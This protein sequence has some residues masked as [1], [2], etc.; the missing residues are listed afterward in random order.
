MTRDQITTLVTQTVGQIDPT[1]IAICND[2]VQRAYEMCWNAHLWRDTVTIDSTASVTAGTNTFTLPSGF[3]RIVSIEML[4]SGTVIGLLDP[5]TTTFILQTEPTSLL[6]TNP[7]TPK[8]Y[9]EFVHT[10]GTRKVRIFPYP[11]NNYTFV[12]SGKRTCPTLSGSSELQI[13]NIDNAVIA[14]A[15]ADMYTRLRQLGKAGEM[16]KKAGAFIQE[17]L[18]I[19]TAQSNQPRVA[20]ATTVT[21]NQFSELIDAV[22]ARVGTWTP[23]NVLLV[24][25]FIK[26]RYRMIWDTHLWRESVTTAAVNAVS[27]QNYI[28]MPTGLERAISI[29]V[30]GKFLDPIDASYLMQVDP[31]IFSRS[32]V[33]TVFEERDVSGAKRIMLYPTPDATYAMVVSGKKTLTNLSGDTDVPV[34]RNIDTALIAFA[35]SDLHARLGQP[36]QSK[37]ALEEAA[38]ALQIM[39]DV[40]TQ[41]TFRA[42]LAK[43]LTV[44]GNSLLEMA[45]AVCARTGQFSLDSIILAKEFLRRNYQMIYDMALWTESTV[46]IDKPSVT[47]TLI[48]PAFVDRVIAVRGNANLGQLSAV[49]PS[50]YYGINPWTFEQTGDPWAFSYL[51]PVAVATLP[52]AAERLSLS[53]SNVVDKSKVFISG[54]L[55]GGLEVAHEQLTLN[56]TTPVLTDNSYLIPLTVAKDVTV[57]NVTINGATS[58]VQLGYIRADERERKHIRLWLQPSPTSNVTCKV[59]CKRAIKPL[60]QDEDTPLLRDVGNALINLATADMFAKIG[61]AKGAEEAKAKGNAALKTLI[62]LEQQQGAITAQVVP[63]VE[64]WGEWDMYGDMAFIS[65]S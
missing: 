2:Y 15:T 23:D 8:K 55:A 27:G 38:A 35:A 37:S 13:R 26:R 20:K 28:V 61:N 21:T 48:L 65:K 32:G 30:E 58:G 12:I 41:Q 52:T 18:D 39:K 3:D 11:D 53:S 33:P 16:A 45:D 1:S 5:T 34:L 6:T 14:L 46:V 50:L 24:R 17:A 4:F 56:G 51:T 10:D 64:P 19:E 29:T 47:G 36:E 57:A 54:E 42:R 43:P 63:E 59:L 31:S 40:E 25:N 49:Q 60:V 9:E 44:A 62:D 7:G 22:C